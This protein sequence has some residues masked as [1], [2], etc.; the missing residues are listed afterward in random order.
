M[1][2]AYIGSSIRDSL[3]QILLF[4]TLPPDVCQAEVEF[5]RRALVRHARGRASA[6]AVD[7][8]NHFAI[9]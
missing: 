1:S 6:D 4:A 8:C 3:E 9:T 5:L 2:D 7:I